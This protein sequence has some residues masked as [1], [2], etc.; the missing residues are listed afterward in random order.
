MWVN[1]LFA[2]YKRE[3]GY[4]Y[5]VKAE[6]VDKLRILSRPEPWTGDY[7]FWVITDTRFPNEVQGVKERG[8]INIRIIRPETDH[9]AGDHLSETALDHYT[10][11]DHIIV[12]DG[13]LEDLK[14]RILEIVELCTRDQI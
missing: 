14:E 13:G 5:D 10:D 2:D 8:G 4:V 12:N 9:L 6:A 7:P 3:A 11:W 1:S